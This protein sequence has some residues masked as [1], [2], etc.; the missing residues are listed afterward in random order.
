M[1]TATEFNAAVPIEVDP[2]INVTEPVGT[3]ALAVDVTVE[4]NVTLAPVA[5]L[6]ADAVNAVLLASRF[7][8]GVT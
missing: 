2:S 4:V 7:S 5:T 1:A 8:G 6:L 3:V